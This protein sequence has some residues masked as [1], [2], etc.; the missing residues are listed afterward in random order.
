MAKKESRI[1][2]EKR[3]SFLSA[4]W[5]QLYVSNGT[6]LTTSDIEEAFHFYEND[7]RIYS[8]VVVE[9][10]DRLGY[11]EK[12]ISYREVD[13]PVDIHQLFSTKLLLM[14]DLVLDDEEI[15]ASEIVSYQE[16]SMYFT[17]FY[18][19]F[20]ELLDKRRIKILVNRNKILEM[21]LM[22]NYSEVSKVCDETCTLINE[23]IDPQLKKF[24]SGEVIDLND[25]HNRYDE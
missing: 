6:V 25:I 10:V 21:G 16:E 22:N 24:T 13:F 15:F 11:V 9:N 18:K 1:E 4:A 17:S 23:I 12:L 20:P 19:H 3:V 2:I 5:Y 8:L 14:N 7:N